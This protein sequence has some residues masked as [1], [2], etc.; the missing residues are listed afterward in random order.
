MG[1]EEGMVSVVGGY[2]YLSFLVFFSPSH[3]IFASFS[4]L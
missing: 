1:A 4:S 2:I 3:L